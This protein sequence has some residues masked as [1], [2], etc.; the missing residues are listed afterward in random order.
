MFKIATRLILSSILTYCVV[1]GPEAVCAASLSPFK[2]CLE[3]HLQ[4]QERFNILEAKQ[5][6][7]AWA[8]TEDTGTSEGVKFD[9][10]CSSLADTIINQKDKTNFLEAAEHQFKV[11]EEKLQQQQCSSD[12]FWAK[13]GVSPHNAVRCANAMLKHQQRAGF[14]DSLMAE[15]ELSEACCIARLAPEYVAE[16]DRR[17][18]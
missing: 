3:E 1:A 2:D 6:M 18:F 8:C 16:I 12:E 5:C 7:V 4:S 15:H 9:G 11:I 10:C 17:E 14:W 13:Y